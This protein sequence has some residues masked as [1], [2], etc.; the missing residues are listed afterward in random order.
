MRKLKYL[1][2]FIL[3]G[4]TASVA[5]ATPPG[6]VKTTIPL[7]APPVGLA[8]D[9][10][11]LLYALEGPAFG[12]NEATLRVFQPDGTP[13]GSYPIVGAEPSNFFVGSMT[14]DPIS[15]GLLISDNTG[16]GRLYAVS[17]AGN[18]ETLATNILNIAGVAVRNT[19]EVFVSTSANAAGEV[20]QVNRTTGATSL[21]LSGL[22]YG[23]GLAFDANGNL[24]VQDANSTTFAG[25]LQR[26]P[27]ASGEAGVV[28]GT[29]EPLLEGM[30]SSAGVIAIGGNEFFTTGVGGLYRVAGPPYSETSFDSSGSSSQ[31]ATAIA[32][33]AG[34]LPFVR[35]AG[36]DGGRL[37]Y[38]A[39]FGFVNQDSFITL[40]TPAEMGDY[41]ADGQVNASDYAVWR[42]SYGS[43]ANLAADGSGN[44]VVDASDYVLW[45]KHA[46]AG[47]ALSAGPTSVPEASCFSLTVV[48]L[49]V[50]SLCAHIRH[51]PRY[52][53]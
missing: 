47:N 26:L 5:A 13:N 6:F 31:F 7:N 35:F 12:N 1:T 41:D 20:L 8:F 2:C 51:T 4:L 11:G 48:C 19:G 10:D 36:P 39:D 23:A 42:A 21:V 24:I 34:A 43:A 9:A 49:V 28:I 16:A 53:A 46:N 45:R 44:G 32:F 3:F 40:L 22:G 17:K 30:L 37:A 38:L 29:A 50:L 33:D 25:R 27:I 18:Q 14:Y 15:D 52:V